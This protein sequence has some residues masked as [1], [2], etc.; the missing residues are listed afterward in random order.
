MKLYINGE[1]HTMESCESVHSALLEDGGK[2]ADIGTTEDLVNKY[3]EVEKI[4]LGGQ[5]VIPGIID[6]HTHVF[7]AA[8]SEKTKALFIPKS[9]DELLENLK[10]QVKEKNPGE[11]IVYKNTYPLRLSEL[12][13]PTLSELTEAAPQNPVCVDGYYSSMLNKCAMETIDYSCLPKGAEIEYDK[14]GKKT[15]LF[16]CANP[17]ISGFVSFGDGDEKTSVISLMREYNKC[18]ITA[19]VDA[20][21]FLSDIALMKAIYDEGKQSIRIRYTLMPIEENIKKALSSDLGDESFAK[22]SFVKNFLDGGFLTGTAFMEYPYHNMESVFGID[23]KG[24]DEFGIVLFTKEQIADSIRLARKYKLSYGAHCVGSAATKRLIEAYETVNSESDIGDERHA[25]IHADFYDE[26]M[27]EKANGMGLSLLFQPAWH[28][29]DAPS[30][31]KVLDARDAERFM[32]YKNIFLANL[33][34]AGSDHMVKHSPDDSVNPY[35]PFT[36]MYNMITCRARDGK[37]YGKNTVSRFDALSA[38]TREGARVCFDEDNIGTLEVGKACDFAVLDKN[39]FE[40]DE[41]EIPAIRSV[42]TV[43]GGKCVWQKKY[44]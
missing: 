25:L 2:I 13:F 1:I 3:P 33:H 24:E 28:Y 5:V 15:G 9:V 32:N 19:A 34:S 30:L 8:Y 38:Y 42:M 44:Q 39:Y 43:V 31:E 11:W 17:Y 18:G 23:T 35:N 7:A 16:K 40:C 12:R 4:D 29:M 14:N 6:S 36:G 21:T 37:A 27:S 22:V 20:N 26:E 41:N 10:E